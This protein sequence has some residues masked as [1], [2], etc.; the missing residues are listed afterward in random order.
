LLFVR[1]KYRHV[2][3]HV[4]EST[5]DTANDNPDSTRVSGVGKR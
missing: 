1:G 3:K 5:A 2:G 4:K